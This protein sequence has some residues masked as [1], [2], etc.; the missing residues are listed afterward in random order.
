MKKKRIR[1]TPQEARRLVLQTIESELLQ[2]GPASFN[3]LEIANKCGLAHTTILHHF[4]T[5]E[6]LKGAVTQHILENILTHAI[7]I[8][9]PNHPQILTID[10]IISL[11]MERL[12]GS[13]NSHLLSWI[14]LNPLEHKT[15]DPTQWENISS[16]LQKLAQLIDERVDKQQSS[17]SA[18]NQNSNITQGQAVQILVATSLI[19]HQLTGAFFGRALGLEEN[20]YKHGYIE[21]F[22][23]L[24]AGQVGVDPL[25]RQQRKDQRDQN[26]VD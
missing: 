15:L 8:L 13:Q 4:G 10:R 2:N 9:N 14:I 6:A 24:I 22:K 25:V 18:L 3:L 16:L 11:F 12:G 21:W 7:E 23:D 17:F 5:V 20:E 26:K 1:R 19:G